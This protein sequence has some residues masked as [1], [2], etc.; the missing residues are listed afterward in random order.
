ML[1]IIRQKSNQMTSRNLV[2]IVHIVKRSLF[3]MI[4]VSYPF[5]LNV[6]DDFVVLCSAGSESMNIV[7]RQNRKEWLILLNLLEP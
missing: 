7:L 4:L 6:L 2:V 5:H 3:F 1:L